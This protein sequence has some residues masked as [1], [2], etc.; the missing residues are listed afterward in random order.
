MRLVIVQW[1]GRLREPAI[2][3]LCEEYRTRFRRFGSLTV[4][5]R[6]ADAPGP[7]PR[8]ARWKVAL[9]EGGRSRTSV[10]LARALREWTMR[11]GEVAFAVG[12]AHGL[13][14]AVLASSDERLALGPLT[15]PHQLAHLLLSEQLYRAAT[16]LAGSPYH[17]AGPHPG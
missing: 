8:G 10:E 2:A 16:I 5:E 14:R 17:H 1:G 7:W 6:E 13:P 3:G 11:H 12:G 15:L 4:E 9:D